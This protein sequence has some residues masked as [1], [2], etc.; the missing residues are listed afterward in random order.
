[1]INLKKGGNFPPF[2]FLKFTE[3]VEILKLFT[4]LS[5]VKFGIK[6]FLP[7]FA[8]PKRKRLYPEVMVE[9]FLAQL[10]RASDY[11]SEG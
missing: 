2:L 11:G 7:I 6:G 5:A 1:M 3:L 8:S 9:A 10:D 4:K